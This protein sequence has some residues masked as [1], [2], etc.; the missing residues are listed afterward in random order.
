[1]TGGKAAPY[2]YNLGN[3]GANAAGYHVAGGGGGAGT[4]GNGV[5][6]GDGYSCDITGETAYYAGG[7]GGGRMWNVP[8]PNGLG[9][10]KENY[11]G[12]GRAS[13]D[14]T[15]TTPQTGGPGI[16]IIRYKRPESGTAVFL[17]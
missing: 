16:V 14:Y 11:G 8:G 9:G 7:G 12:G 10:G 6:G 5:A 2:P 17:R 3:D 13:A 4:A 1:M 15:V